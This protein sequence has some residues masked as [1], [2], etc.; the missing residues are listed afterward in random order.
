MATRDEANAQ[1]LL[2][3]WQ[4]TLTHGVPIHPRGEEVKETADFQLTMD[5]LFPF[6]SFEDRRYNLQYFKEEMAWKLGANKY[7]DSIKQ[8][9]KMWESVQN[10]DG[11]F[12]SNYGQ[13]WWGDQ[14]GMWTVIEELVR[15]KDSRRAVIPMLCK[16][17]MSPQT[18]D[19]VCTESV[20]FRIR[21]NTLMMSVHMRSSDQVFGLGTDIPTF[22]VLM[23]LI[24]G[25]L[26]LRYPDL[27]LG[28]I[29]ITA[30]SSHIYSRHYEMLG[31]VLAKGMAGY[32]PIK[33][34]LISGPAEALAI[35]SSR[36]KYVD[37]FPLEFELAHWLRERRA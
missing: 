22:S 20:G 26:K 15:D 2:S 17:H 29:T 30:M 21:Y 35:V 24:F 10:P 14:K 7:D 12:N 16:D 3:M 6:Q 18:K 27:E 25:M 36:G 34:P 37:G 5:P 31:K 11:T 32:T 1:A 19:T 9:A 33:L 4:D 28:T 13:Y 8:H 23:Q